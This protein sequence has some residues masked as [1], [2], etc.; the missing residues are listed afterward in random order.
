MPGENWTGTE[1]QSL[2]G[3]A[4]KLSRKV[5]QLVRL[6]WSADEGP[7]GHQFLG[8]GRSD[9]EDSARRQASML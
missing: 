8:A 4:R 3:E 9:R 2:I 1:K 5:A 7:L 6:L